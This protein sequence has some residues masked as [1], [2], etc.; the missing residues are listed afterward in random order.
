MIPFD[1]EPTATFLKN[2][3]SSLNHASFV[4]QAV[5]DLLN[6]GCIREVKNIPLCTNPLSVSV[7]S[8]GKE[9][10]I[11]DL[12]HVNQFI[13]KFKVKFESMNGALD[14]C[15]QG[16]LM[17]KF[18]LCSGYYHVNIHED[19]QKFL[20]FSWEVDGRQR[21]FVYTVMA[22]GLSSAPFLFTK[23]LRPLVKYR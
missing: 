10:L 7:N 11:L 6:L 18:D 14:F 8:S 15:K 20:G 2:N 9:R 21:F 19:Y 22:F 4:T 3:R 13:H 5:N 23:L 17:F 16:N 12:R 1:S